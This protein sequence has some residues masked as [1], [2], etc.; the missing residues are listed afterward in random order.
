MAEYRRQKRYFVGAQLKNLRGKM[1]QEELAQK[2]GKRGKTVWRWENDS[3]YG[4]KE[5][6]CRKIAKALGVP[7]EELTGMELREQ[8]SLS[9]TLEIKHYTRLP[10][11]GTCPAS[12][13]SWTPD[14]VERWVEFPKEQVRGR[15]L[16][17]LR[18]R[19]DSMNRAGIDDADVVIVDADREPTNGQIVVARIDSES[20]IKRFYRSEDRITLTPDSTNP[21]HQPQ[22][23]TKKNEVMLRGCVEAT[24]WK[25]VK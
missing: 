7:F 12:E 19:G 5:D 20:T 16:Y 11:L 9:D 4:I 3:G 17:L 8:I 25:K 1:S 6:D 14:Q 13:K 2:I 10:L 15:R 23:F 21:K 22:T 18:V 24:W